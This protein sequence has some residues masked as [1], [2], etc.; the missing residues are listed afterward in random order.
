MLR[1]HAYC[2]HSS[3]ARCLRHLQVGFGLSLAFAALASQAQEAVFTPLGPLV[4]GGHHTA[5]VKIAGS[6][7]API[8]VASFPNS[9]L[10]QWTADG[11]WQ[12]LSTRYTTHGDIS[13]NG[14]WLVAREGYINPAII[15]RATGEPLPLPTFPVLEGYSFLSWRPIGFYGESGL[16]GSATLRLDSTGE[17]K[18]VSFRLDLVTG[19]YDLVPEQAPGGIWLPEPVAVSA[20]TGKL[21]IF[22]GYGSFGKILTLDTDGTLHQESQDFYMTAQARFSPDGRWMAVIT[23]QPRSGLVESANWPQLWDLQSTPAT[24]SNFSQWAQEPRSRSGETKIRHIQDNGIAYGDISGEV[25]PGNIYASQATVWHPNGVR[26]SLQAELERHYGLDLGGWMLA[27]VQSVSQDGRVLAGLGR[28]PVG[29]NHKPWLI[30]L[31]ESMPAPVKVAEP[32]IWVQKWGSNEGGSD[33]SLSHAFASTAFN[34]NRYLSVLFNNIGDAPLELTSAEF[35][36]P[37]ADQFSVTSLPES[38]LIGVGESDVLTI[39]FRPTSFGAKSAVL[40]IQTNDPQT[41]EFTFNLTGEG[42][43]PI[44]HFSEVYDPWGDGDGNVDLKTA[45]GRSVEA[46]MTLRNNGNHDATDL[47]AEI[48][49][50]N[51][52]GLEI[53]TPPPATLAA[54]TS[55][56]IVLRFTP[57]EMG[58]SQ[59]TILIRSDHPSVQ[60]LS[61]PLRTVAVLPVQPVVRDLA[62]TL[63]PSGTGEVNFEQV[64]ARATLS[65]PIR[66]ENPGDEAFY[67]KLKLLGRHAAE[68]DID[69]PT[70]HTENSRYRVSAKGYLTIFPV[71][72]PSYSTDYPLTATLVIDAPTHMVEP[73][74]VKLTGQAMANGAPKFFSSPQT[75]INTP[76]LSKAEFRVLG[77]TPMSYRIVKDRTFGTWYRADTMTS[78]DLKHVKSADDNS[79]YHIEL[80][81]EYGTTRSPPFRRLKPALPTFHQPLVGDNTSL[82][83]TTTITQWSGLECHWLKDGVP[84]ILDEVISHSFGPSLG[85]Q[86]VRSSDSGRYSCLIKTTSPYSGPDTLVEATVMD[87]IGPPSVEPF[88]IRPTQ[89]LEMVDFHLR[90]THQSRIDTYFTVSGLP[91]GIKYSRYGYVYG[92]VALSAAARGTRDYQVTV[93]AENSLG[94]GE[95]YTTTWRV[96]PFIA[97]IAGTYHGTIARQADHDGDR[98]LGGSVTLTVNTTGRF[99]GRILTGGISRSLKGSLSSPPPENLPESYDPPLVVGLEIGTGQNG[100]QIITGISSPIRMPDGAQAQ[101]AF[102]IE[103]SILVGVLQDSPSSLITAFRQDP[104]PADMTEGK[105]AGRFHFQ[106]GIDATDESEVTLPEGRGF[107]TLLV[108]PSGGVNWVGKLPEGTAFTGRSGISH[109]ILHGQPSSWVIPLHQTLYRKQGSVQGLFAFQSGNPVGEAQLDWNKTPGTKP[110][111]LY[112]RIPLTTLNG[113]GSRYQWGKGAPLL[114]SAL[115]LNDETPNGLLRLQSTALLENL[116]L[117]FTLTD[118]GKITVPN[119]VPLSRPTLKLAAKTALF[120]LKSR[121]TQEATAHRALN[122]QALWIPHLKKAVGV[123]T[124]PE[125]PDATSTPPK[126]VKTTPIRA[127]LLKIS[128]H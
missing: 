55:A 87:V 8:V 52:P 30:T 48:I 123:F 65:L 43:T 128:I 120:T 58:S 79:I 62:G 82:T 101:V 1:L 70:G 49:G 106:L 29:E 103:G 78:V 117:S 67:V 107:A 46:S 76:T 81:N 12:L 9:G 37:S 111:H 60:P 6:V 115:D 27:S 34:A 64:T 124:L 121:L 90:A 86:G 51:V 100:P 25:L 102:G 108:S 97:D 66:L 44:L 91:P 45:V 40:K 85:F 104:A 88:S 3:I 14:T 127:G 17:S 92:Q 72:E 105:K 39:H 59:G 63:L 11:G 7:E 20:D 31:S 73:Y 95:P 77:T 13:P 94:R 125:V 38:G 122:G 84:V 126:S 116:D 35:S 24:R 57:T 36:G 2:P 50:I 32:E 41:P 5:E 53:L 74:I 19:I 89:A 4:P 118:K 119:P 114:D 33:T 18:R 56:T 112:P 23:D 71:F 69:M 98:A 26:V 22:T 96:E 10:A 99:T 54:G 110:D 109:L 28:N 42:P 113:E 21:A 68:Y 83:L 16:V 61:L 80:K 75:E 15:V 93:R 47:Q